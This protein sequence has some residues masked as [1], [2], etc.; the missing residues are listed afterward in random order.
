MFVSS[1]KW[2]IIKKLLIAIISAFLISP[3]FAEDYIYTNKDLEKYKIS[4]EKIEAPA[5]EKV[6][7]KSKKQK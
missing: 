3:A 7:N 4:P 2:R 6:K 1:T 5:P